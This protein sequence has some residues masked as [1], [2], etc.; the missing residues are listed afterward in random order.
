[1]RLDK[2]LKA[3]RLIKRR[4]V[5]QSACEGGYI[6]VNGKPQK[7]SCQLKVG[8]EIDVTFGRNPMRVRVLALTETT[9]KEDAGHMY[10]VLS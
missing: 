8:D 9:K 6:L 1:M 10:E 2:F 5:A 3:S 7:S 4:T